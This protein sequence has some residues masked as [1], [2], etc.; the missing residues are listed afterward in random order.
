MQIVTSLSPNHSCKANQ[1]T[2]IASWK[3]Y[4]DCYSLNNPAEIDKLDYDIQVVPVGRTLHPILQKYLIN[5]NS[6]LDFAT[7]DLLYLNSDI[8]LKDLPEFKQDGVTILSRY[9]YETDI[10]QTTLFTHGFDAFYV[11][12]TFLNEFPPSVYAL[13]AAW[14]DH[15]LPM[16]CIHKQIPLYYPMGKFAFHKLH[17][18]Q[19]SYAEWL[20]LGEYFRWEFQIPKH[21]TAGQIATMNMNKIRMYCK[22]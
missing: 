6:I 21:L 13:G 7:D 1:S 22:P 8:I 12:K 18:V 20:R 14:H 17:E 15:W 10:N 16:W 9:D 2:A 19:Y 3:Q 11:P 4:G 5:I